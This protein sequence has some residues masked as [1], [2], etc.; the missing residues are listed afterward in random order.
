MGE[1]ESKEGKVI[2]RETVARA[3][4]W[5]WV[6]STLWRAIEDRLSGHIT[7]GPVTI[8]GFNAMHCAVNVRTRRWGYVC[9]KPPTFVF[10][11][12]WPGYFYCSPDATPQSATFDLTGY[13]R[14]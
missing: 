13:S 8:Y 4:K 6:H 12:W 1:S 2:V 10:G 3:T 9:F 11:C 5:L 14:E 7:V